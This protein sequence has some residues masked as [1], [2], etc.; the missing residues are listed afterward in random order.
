MTNIN[1]PKVSIVVPTYNVEPY[2]RECLDSLVSQTLKEI[3]II[4]IDDGSPDR[5][6]EIMDEYAAKDPR[7]KAIHKANGGY[8]SAVNLGFAEAQGEYIGIVEPDDWV[9][10]DMYEKLYNQAKR[11]DAD[12]CKAPF[13]RWNSFAPESENNIEF[14]G[15]VCKISNID[16]SKAH[17]IY[18]Q[19]DIVEYHSS[20]WSSIYRRQFLFE[21][22]IM[23]NDTPGAS[24]QDFPFMMEVMCRAK[25]IA[26]V[27]DILYHWRVE[28]NQQSS[29]NAN[30]P[31][32]MYMADNS[33]IAV[34]FLIKNGY[35]K[36]VKDYVYVHILNANY[37]FFRKIDKK[38]SKDYRNRLKRAF[39]PFYKGDRRY[40]CPFVNPARDSFVK[41]YIIDGKDFCLWTGSNLRR[42]IIQLHLNRRSIK[43]ALFG[44]VIYDSNR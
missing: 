16:D 13:A 6:G 14:E 44:Y 4:I 18:D 21:N 25:R 11:L 36:T 12:V 23:I 8:A 39:K 28:P 32:L 19:P 38:Y 3:E 20:I 30:G 34:D 35:F 24:Y 42:R 15:T 9:E 41:D 22:N 40:K 27:H 37:E 2:F 31:K 1:S 29:T 7:I 17:T 26:V 10:A 43:L 5:C 33:I